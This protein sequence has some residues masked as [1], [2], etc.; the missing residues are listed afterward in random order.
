MR[1]IKFRAWSNLLERMIYSDDPRQK[2]LGWWG[3]VILD[4]DRHHG[5]S[6]MQF[7]GLKDRHGKEVYEGDIVEWVENRSHNVVK[8]RHAAFFAGAPLVNIDF[9]QHPIEVIGNIY[10]NPDLVR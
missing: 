2:S 9:R 4:K 7:T 1:E 3:V 10:E 8:F 5:E 6:T